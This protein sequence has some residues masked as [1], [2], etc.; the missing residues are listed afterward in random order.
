[1][2]FSTK[3]ILIDAR[4]HLMGRLAAI[5]A[6]TIL[7]GQRV[8]IVRCEGINISGNFYR[9]KLKYLKYLKYRCN[10]NPSRGPFHYRAPSRI[11]FKAVKGMIPHTTTRGKEALGRLKVFE[12]VP[13]PYDKQKRK[14]VP[15][16]L[17]I[18]RLKQ[19][20]RYCDLNRLAHEVGWKYQGVIGTLE[21]KRKVKSKK[22]YEN[23]KVADNL[24][25]KARLNVA[26]KIAQYQKVIE[27]YGYR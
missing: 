21:A 7:Q 14:V 5:V 12:G 10:V 15:A 24:R 16:A 17:R 19:N 25:A 27:G 3:P 2:G 20:R 6:K 23:K 1:M 4:G 18:L 8:V 22:F 9:N 13:P 26:S 11:F